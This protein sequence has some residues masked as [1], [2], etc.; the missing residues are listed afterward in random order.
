MTTPTCFNC[1]TTDDVRPYS[2]DLDLPTVQAC[3]RCVFAL[4]MDDEE[5]LAALRPRKAGRKRSGR[6][7]A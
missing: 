2:F 4:S 5:L 1:A 6:M 3:P 7:T